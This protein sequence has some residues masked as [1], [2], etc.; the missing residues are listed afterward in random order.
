MSTNKITFLHDIYP[1]SIC[2]LNNP[3]SAI[4]H[5]N[6]FLEWRTFLNYLEI[7]KVYVVSLEYVPF[8]GLFDSDYPIITLSEPILITKN[9]SPETISKFVKKQIIQAHLVFNF[10]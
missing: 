8:W 9:S 5:I 1:D 4:L 10:F 6:D 3:K 7:D 2:F